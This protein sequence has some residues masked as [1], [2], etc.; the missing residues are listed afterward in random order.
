MSS[1]NLA[2][3]GEQTI[4]GLRDLWSSLQSRHERTTII[5]L[6]LICLSVIFSTAI[7]QAL[8]VALTVLVLAGGLFGHSFRWRR[9]PLDAPYLVFLVGRIASIALS[10]YPSQSLR[11]LYVEYFFYLMFFLVTQ[12]IR[13]D[14]LS[15]A[16]FLT[17][18]LVAAGVVAGL[19]GALKVIL[20]ADPRGSSTTAGPYTLGTFLCPVLALALFLPRAWKEGK[21]GNL[22]RLAPLIIC[23]G[24]L[25]TFDRLHWFGMAL[26]LAAGAL[27]L[28]RRAGFIAAC[29]VLL[30]A[31]VLPSVRVRIE[32]TM[33]LGAFMAGRDVLWRGASL[34]ITDH[35][36]AGFGPRTFN[37]IFPLFAEMPIRGVGSWHNDYLQ[38]YMES[39]LLGLLPLLWIIGATYYQCWNLFRATPLPSHTRA[40]VL[41]L[42]VSISAVVLLGG[43]LDTHVGI[44]FR[45]LLGLLA[46][47]MGDLPPRIMAPAGSSA[48]THIGNVTHS[49]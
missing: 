37:S 36:I 33:D 25:S 5:L 13:G 15:T 46:L 3:R 44:V 31:P 4:G 49:A 24:I 20:L 28:R 47:M 11:A 45:I 2:Q 19:I 35:P 34:L 40:F 22:I 16:R 41:S 8:V 9:T 26:I 48:D 32:Q 21:G 38:V 29:F 39:G 42:L 23:L 14:E 7:V 17:S 43:M 12:S 6:A 18:L 30:L 1:M 27:L 10:Q